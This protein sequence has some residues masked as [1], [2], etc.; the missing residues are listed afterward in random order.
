MSRTDKDLPYWYA[1]YYEP[2][3]YCIEHGTQARWI[4]KKPCDLPELTR[5]KLRDLGYWGNRRGTTCFWEPLHERNWWQGNPP[6]WYI[7]HTWYEPERVRIRDHGRKALQDYNANGDTEFD[8]PNYQH[9]HRS[10][11]YWW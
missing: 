11:W 10:S 5:K 4:N 6:K 3:H 7:N 9:R 8:I 2:N 1:E